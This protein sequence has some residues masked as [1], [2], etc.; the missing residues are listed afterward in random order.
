[1]TVRCRQC[2]GHNA[3]TDVKPTRVGSRRSS[4]VRPVSTWSGCDDRKE[5]AFTQSLG[6]NGRTSRLDILGP[7][8]GMHAQRG[9][10]EQ[11]VEP[12]S[13]QENDERGY[14]A[15]QKKNGWAGW[16]PSTE[17]AKVFFLQERDGI[18]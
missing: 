16:R 13:G 4:T 14:F 18:E 8:V 10:V 6:S 2:T 1:M 7:K 5:K 15:Q 11:C 3:G 9:Q 17:D 12:Q